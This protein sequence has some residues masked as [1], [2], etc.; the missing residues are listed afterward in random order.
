MDAWFDIR[1]VCS[2]TPRFKLL[3]FAL[4]LCIYIYNCSFITRSGYAVLR[5]C[6]GL[7]RASRHV[8][9]SAVVHT[10]HNVLASAPFENALRPTAASI[11]VRFAHAD[12]QGRIGRVGKQR[13]Q[14]GFGGTEVPQ[15]SPGAKPGRGSGGEVP[16]NL[17]RFGYMFQ[18]NFPFR[19]FV[20]DKMHVIITP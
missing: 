20:Y 1:V 3:S 19:H 6:A 7:T 11:H 14:R 17:K 10:Q 4:H 12:D 13:R 16:Q 2:L 8:A 5:R 9:I 18:V 15:W